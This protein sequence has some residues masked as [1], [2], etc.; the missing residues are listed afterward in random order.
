MNS[1]NCGK[2]IFQCTFD[3]YSYND[4]YTACGAL[5]ITK[6]PVNVTEP[7]LSGFELNQLP[8]NKQLYIT[9]ITSISKS[10]FDPTTENLKPHN[11]IG[12]VKGCQFPYSNSDFC[13]LQSSQYV[14]QIPS[15]NTLAACDLGLNFYLIFEFINSI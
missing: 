4:S 1:I 15:T 9:D 10:W 7:T 5:S 8:S 6:S 11:L 2:N 3:G 13:F 12:S 14:C